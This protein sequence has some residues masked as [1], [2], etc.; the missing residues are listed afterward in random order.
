MLKIF[1]NVQSTS[2]SRLNILITAWNDSGAGHF[3]RLLDSTEDIFC[4]PFETLLGSN[5]KAGIYP[6]PELVNPSYRWNVFRFGLSRKVSFHDSGEQSSPYQFA[7]SELRAWL[8]GSK[9]D[10]LPNHKAEALKVLRVYASQCTEKNAFSL[11]TTIG[12][13]DALE[14]VFCSELLAARAMHVPC[15]MLDYANPHFFVIFD[16][17]LAL[18]IDPE[19]GFGNMAQRN[20][21]SLERYLRRW[22]AI[23]RSTHTAQKD[24]P[25]RVLVLRS[26]TNRLEMQENIHNAIEFI[27]GY[28][29]SSRLSHSPF[30]TLL[31]GGLGQAGY[32]FGGV[33]SWNSSHE[34]F[35]RGIT[36]DQLKT[37]SKSVQEL[38]EACG[39]LFGEMTQ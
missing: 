1:G 26:S 34:Q 17:I 7:E 11:Q 13:L 20:S 32:P 33:L 15:A 38:A 6:C 10:V 21:I 28:G 4:F 18:V 9:F 24:Y 27:F 25:D 8:E 36:A 3:T 12:Y 2:N 29:D 23:N 19:W 16:K 39:S 35:S 22:L 30:P 31:K 14:K 5:A 37:S